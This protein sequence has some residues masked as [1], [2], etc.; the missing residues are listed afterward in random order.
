MLSLSCNKWR[1][2]LLALLLGGYAWMGGFTPP[3][4]KFGIEIAPMK[5]SEA[6]VWNAVMFC[7]GAVLASVIDHQVGS[8]SPFLSIR[9]I[10]VV[11]GILLMVFAIIWHNSMI[12]SWEES[13]VAER[14]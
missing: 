13:V 12:L 7:F 11:I 14:P 5:G 10:Y 6:W 4:Q 8:T 9:S 3:S 2:L 1:L